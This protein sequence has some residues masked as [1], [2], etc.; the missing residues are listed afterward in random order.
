MVGGFPC[1]VYS[2]GTLLRNSKGLKGTKGILWWEI[3]RLL[4][5][6]H[7]ANK[8]PQYLLFENVDRLLKS[9]SNKKGNFPPLNNGE[10][11]FIL[12]I[13]SAKFPETLRMFLI[14]DEVNMKETNR[15]NL[16]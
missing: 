4:L 14:F 12:C 11:P 1:Q 13:F 5:G 2:V 15:V 7:A 16:F 6:L 10:F 3:N 8:S 9:P